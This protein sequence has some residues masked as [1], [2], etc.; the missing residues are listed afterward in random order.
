MVTASEVR[1]VAAG[2]VAHMIANR[3][4]WH[5]KKARN[6]AASLQEQMQMLRQVGCEFVSLLR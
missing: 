1:V 4:H 6:P 5:Q 2:N 3:P